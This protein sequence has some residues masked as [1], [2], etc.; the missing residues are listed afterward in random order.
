MPAAERMT[1]VG[2]A[3]CNAEVLIRRRVHVNHADCA[4][5]RFSNSAII[6]EIHTFC[7]TKS[8]ALLETR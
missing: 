2:M 6:S 4:S 7:I 3:A 5:C 8:S 1:G